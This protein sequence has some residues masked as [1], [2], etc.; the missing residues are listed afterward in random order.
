MNVSTYIRQQRILAAE[1]ML[2]QQP[3]V[4]VLAIGLSVGFNS[5]SAFYA[6]FKALH[7]MAPGQFRKRSGSG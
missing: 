2:L 5:Q 4:S 1:K 3:Q 6:A 7:G